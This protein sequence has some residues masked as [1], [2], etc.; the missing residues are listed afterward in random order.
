MCNL[1][2]G[3][4]SPFKH[5]LKEYLGYDITKFRDNIRF[6]EVLINRGGSPGGICPLYFDGAVNYFQELP[7]PND[8]V[9]LNRVYQLL[10]N[11]RNKSNKVMIAFGYSKNNAKNLQTSNSLYKFATIFNKLK[12]KFKQWQIV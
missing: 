4:F 10:S 2:V 12:L 8:N 5:D 11:I 3:I 9:G 6:A 7:L 1:A